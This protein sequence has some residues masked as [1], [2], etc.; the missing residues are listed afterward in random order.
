M[1]ML[2]ADTAEF[3]AY[4]SDLEAKQP[5]HPTNPFTL[6]PLENLERPVHELFELRV[7]LNGDRLALR[8]QRQSFTYTELNQ[9]ANRL[10]HAILARRGAAVEAVAILLPHSAATVVGIIGV[11]KT[12]KFYIYFDPLHPQTRLLDLLA[13]SETPLIV[14]NTETMPLAEM[15]VAAGATC[16][17][18][19]LDDLSN[20]LPTDNPN[21]PVTGDDTMALFYTSG[22]TGKPKGA[23]KRHRP[24]VLSSMLRI[25]TF[26][27]WEEDR[28]AQ[29][30][31][32]S[33][34]TSTQAVFN[35][36]FTGAS[37]H[38]IDLKTEP[39]NKVPDWMRDEAITVF[40]ATPSIF[41][42]WA[43]HLTDPAQVASIR[44]A[45]LGGETVHIQDFETYRRWFP[46][47]CLFSQSIGAT[48]TGT[49]AIYMMDKNTELPSSL[50][51]VGF[52]IWGKEI[53]LLDED[54]QPVGAGEVGEIAVKSRML[55]AGYWREPEQTADKF[56]ADADDATM[57]T[58]RT[59][60][61]GRFTPEGALTHL[62]RK[63]WQVKIRGQRVELTE[64]EVA[65]LQHDDVKQTVVVAI[66]Q[67]P[68]GVAQVG[69][70]QLVAYV[71]M[72]DPLNAPPAA[73]FRAFAAE[74]LPIHMVPA[75]YI[76]IDEL[77]LTPTNKVDRQRLLTPKLTQIDRNGDYVPP[78]DRLEFELTHLWENALGVDNIG[79]RDD[80][81]ALGGHS[82]L[83]AYLFV[84]MEEKFGKSVP[85]TAL[86]EQPTI[87]G[88]ADL[89]RQ[90]A[91]IPS[92][93]L[94][95]IQAGDADRP[96]LFCF[97]AR[98][99]FVLMY[100]DLAKHLGTDQ[101]V[102]GLQTPGIDGKEPLLTDLAA[103]A[104]RYVETIRDVQPQGPYHL[105]G[106][107]LGGTLALEVGH[108]LRALGE[109]VAFTGI[110]D[111]QFRPNGQT[112][113]QPRPD[114]LSARLIWSVTSIVDNLIGIPPAY[115][116]HYLRQK[117]SVIRQRLAGEETEFPKVLNPSELPPRLQQVHEAN[118]T[119]SRGYTYRPYPGRVHYFRC[120][121][122]ILDVWVFRMLNA[123]TTGDYEIIDVPGTHENIVQE[124]QI[125]EL[126]HAV[127]E[128]LD[129]VI[130]RQTRH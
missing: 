128:A 115:K 75:F 114:S 5:A 93:P 55:S 119:A 20:T 72:D 124:P 49:I 84:Q 4:W 10:A 64:I 92:T 32:F 67:Q 95:P 24:R 58:Y 96:P 62:G 57:K 27:V 43:R 52:P 109:T 70:K 44:I 45:G 28:I 39:V 130:A 38:L 33:F 41:R 3:S 19:N 18:I 53:L 51:P 129:M 21:I 80:F 30:S 34:G 76:P 69:D 100:R 78:R 66:D 54:G 87:E 88:I 31:S 71:V 91:D 56:V 98:G 48:E 83:A 36:L 112:F 113:R 97:H 121:H 82:L 118:M 125:R 11:I 17:V 47:T 15:L 86:F 46:D 8:D 40:H 35:A 37:L 7:E 42:H 25:N 26:H 77:P 65:L 79:A 81:F 120:D 104:T 110:V 6:M 2:K 89:L 106:Y 107:S 122:E 108:Q 103:M 16:E 1:T 102:Y 12:G 63:D 99:G 14:T 126:A 61:L 29:M 9:A 68:N 123:V 73:E 94:V 59:G 85:L 60:D 127:R 111:T 90:E 13:D 116:G 117:L 22:S 50:V 101:P 23:L 74:R 105:C